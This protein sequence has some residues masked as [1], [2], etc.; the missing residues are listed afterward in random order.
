MFE[1]RAALAL[2]LCVV[3]T[4]AFGMA[5]LFA[6]GVAQAL[7]L[8]VALVLVLGVALVFEFRAALALALGVVLALALG[9]VLALRLVSASVSAFTWVFVCA[10][11]LARV[12][13][14]VSSSASTTMGSAYRATAGGSD[15][16]GQ[17][18]RGTA[19]PAVLALST[20]RRHRVQSSSVARG[21]PGLTR[22]W[23]VA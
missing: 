3:L 4:L 10:S 12:S 5:L 9:V 16:V 19:R 21:S 8:G 11:A 2:A 23:A 17:E 20:A 7:V 15:K 6:L 22:R 14:L 13:S 1:F 18:C